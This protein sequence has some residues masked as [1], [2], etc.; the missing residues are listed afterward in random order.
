MV[1]G[2]SIYGTSLYGDVPDPLF[3]SP[4][5]DLWYNARWNDVTSD[6]WQEPGI[7]IERGWS[8]ETDQGVT[9]ST[10]RFTFISTDGRYSTKNPNSDLHGLIGRNTPVRVSCGAPPTAAAATGSGG[11]TATAPSVVAEE[12]GIQY[13]FVH[14][15]PVGNLTTPG[16]F[17]AGTERDSTLSTGNSFRKT[18]TAGVTGTTAVT[19]SATLT[20][21]AAAT[22]VV[23]GGTHVDANS[24][25][26]GTGGNVDVNQTW[27]SGNYVLACVSWSADTRAEMGPPELEPDPARGWQLLA[28]TGPGDTAT[29]RMMVWGAWMSED[30]SAGYVYGPLDDYGDTYVS[31][32]EIEVDQPWSVRFVGEISEWPQQWDETAS[33]VWTPVVASGV[34]RRLSQNTAARSSIRQSVQARPSVHEYWPMEDEAGGYASA[35]GGTPMAVYG[36]PVYATQAFRGSQDLSTFTGAGALG[37]V[38]SHD[39]EDVRYA[40]CVFTIPASGTATGANIVSQVFDGAGAVQAVVLEYTNTTTFTLKTT[41][42]DGTATASN[43]LS[44]FSSSIVGQKLLAVVAATQDGADVDVF[45][46]VLRLDPDYFVA[47]ATC[48]ASYSGTVASKTVARCVQAG[49]GIELG[50][51][52]LLHTNAPAFGHLAVGSVPI[53]GIIIDAL[54]GGDEFLYG[55]GSLSAFRGWVGEV[56]SRRFVHTAR[57]AGVLVQGP[58][59]LDGVKQGPERIEPILARLQSA[60]AAHPSSQLFEASGFGGYQWRWPR[61]YLPDAPRVT[62]GHN[63]Q[64]IE[65]P[66]DA[67]DDDQALVNA[68]TVTADTGFRWR[69]Q[70]DA[71]VAAAGL[72]EASPALNTYDQD[73]TR[74][75]AEWTVHV[76]TVEGLRWPE[77]TFDL[78]AAGNAGIRDTVYQAL[79]I[80]D[81]VNVT[82]LPDW[83]AGEAR[84]IVRGMK[85]TIG[86]YR[87]QIGLVCAPSEP[88]RAGVLD[89]EFATVGDD[90]GLATSEALSTVE[91][92]VD[93]TGTLFDPAATS[94]LYF[95]ILI[96]GERMTVTDVT[97]S[98][99]TVIRSVNGI[100]K[101][102]NS[103]EA[104]TVV[105]SYT[106]L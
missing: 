32:V 93:F 105:A 78:A 20:G 102:H 86:Q 25:N 3:L 36:A 80:G 83:G 103:G 33:L 75:A 46:A 51:G 71:S 61:Y 99:L 64:Q 45:G 41:Y 63:D 27:A 67:T 49:V 50:T 84:L 98:T 66:F 59:S 85:E 76:G 34:T 82:D 22:V 18:V 106:A 40:L 7:E 65:R 13:V 53:G 17:T 14:A 43:A 77:I 24:G 88:F 38:R 58:Y 26:T 94:S 91:T 60:A 16:G 96:E 9:P 28:D 37:T 69:H 56:T 57:G 92:D 29:P 55:A 8:G 19:H 95:D 6:V 31:F 30:T 4:R 104:I 21:W 12:D 72:Y 90:G 73:W 1:Y 54:E 35:V 15:R 101:E 89:S 97:G 10:A 79:E 44:A 68:A 39:P 48:I 70:D 62:F 11:T 81:C 23:P 42:N 52:G 87:H 74:Y 47:D 100:V 5:V 2:S